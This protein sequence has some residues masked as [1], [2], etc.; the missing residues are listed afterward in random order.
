MEE[1]KTIKAIIKYPDKKPQVVN[2]FDSYENISE[3]VSGMIEQV[4][5]PGHDDITI[6]CNDDFIFNGMSPN[7]ILPE[8]ENVL[9]GPLIFTGYD[10]E[11][12]DTVSLNEKQIDAVMDYCEKNN[13]HHMSLAGAYH[14]SKAINVLNQC[15][16]ALSKE[17]EMEM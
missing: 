5:L 14:Y 13:L 9:C 11:T 17:E 3:F 16:D 6:I 2:F 7:I 12:G 1:G 8:R 4:A 10:N 15:L